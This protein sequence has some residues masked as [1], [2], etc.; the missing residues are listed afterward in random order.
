MS[1]L[2]ELNDDDQQQVAQLAGL[3]PKPKVSPPSPYQPITPAGK[4]SLDRVISE[5]DTDKATTQQSFNRVAKSGLSDTLQALLGKHRFS[6]DSSLAGTGTL[7][8]NNMN[9]GIRFNPA[10]L[11]SFANAQDDAK[12]RAR[13]PGPEGPVDTTY[14]SPGAESSKT[15][16]H[17]FG[18]T[19][20]LNPPLF[21]G[22]DN[23][24][25]QWYQIVSKKSALNPEN[26]QGMTHKGWNVDLHHNDGGGNRGADEMF[27]DAFSSAVNL[28]R[29]SEDGDRSKYVTQ[30]R[31]VENDN[32]GTIYLSK[33]LVRQPAFQNHPA[34]QWLK[35]D[36][37]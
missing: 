11:E 29:R 22:A 32:P 13:F 19:A 14:M 20:E 18:H 1:F 16:A 28:L 10:A 34:T 12:Y 26:T 7:A 27:A 15:L 6:V 23:L 31:S 25:G 24:Y 8:I 33:W 36:L 30:L 4:Q 17:E 21:P 3:D 37:K 5:A 35:G 9:H 2:D